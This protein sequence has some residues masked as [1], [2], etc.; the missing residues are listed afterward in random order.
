MREREIAAAVVPEGK[1]DFFLWDDRIKGLALRVRAR[2][3]TFVFKTRIDGRARWLNIGRW[4]SITLTDARKIARGFAVEIASGKDPAES[5]RL[6]PQAA[7]PGLLRE[8][9]GPPT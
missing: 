6:G 9:R 4:G 5:R 3:N 2:S 1:K 7:G 8:F